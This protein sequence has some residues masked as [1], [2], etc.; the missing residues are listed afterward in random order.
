MT[1]SILL[2]VHFE[3][4]VFLLGELD[5]LTIKQIPTQRNFLFVLFFE[6]ILAVIKNLPFKSISNIIP[7]FDVPLTHAIECFDRRTLGLRLQA[8]PSPTV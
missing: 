4:A 8:I 5:L 3:K 2:G 6:I 7:Y 1:Q